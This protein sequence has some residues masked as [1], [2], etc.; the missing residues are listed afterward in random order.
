MRAVNLLRRYAAFGQGHGR[1]DG[2]A[3]VATFRCRFVTGGGRCGSW[4]GPDKVIEDSFASPHLLFPLCRTDIR[5]RRVDRIA[6][7]LTAESRC[8]ARLR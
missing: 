5:P 3:A 6:M 7:I 1:I 8:H 4:R 2:L